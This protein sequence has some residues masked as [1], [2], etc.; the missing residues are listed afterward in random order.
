MNDIK[1]KFMDRW[2]RYFPGAELPLVFY[3]TDDDS[4]VKPNPKPDDWRCVI[5]DLAR[6]RKGRA[7][8]FDAESIS[9]GGGKRYMGLAD[10][11]RPKI[12]Y[13]LSCGIPGEMEGIRFKKT[14][15]LVGEMMKNQKLFAAPGRFI[16]FK[17][18]DITG[19][20]D[21]PVAVI[22]FA[23]PDVLSGLFT[24][25]NYDQASLFSVISPS[26]SGCSAIVYYPYLESQ[27]EHPRAILGMFDTSARPCV[28]S[29]IL[30]FAVPYSRFVT[31]VHNMDESNLTTDTWKKIRDRISRRR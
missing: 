27:T 7:V 12:E 6:A 17:R 1:S 21:Q 20:K 25:A 22:F 2:E 26:C 9:C 3:Y 11:P 13:F 4:E 5:C 16:V 30:T 10:E 28:A 18:W 23:E 24:L 19:D 8:A 31:M 29:G 14:P 15:E